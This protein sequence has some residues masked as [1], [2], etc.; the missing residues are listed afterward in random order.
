MRAM[1]LT[2]YSLLLLSTA[3]AQSPD[4][5]SY[6]YMYKKEPGSDSTTPKRNYY[7][8]QST[9]VDS[10]DTA[11]V[12]GF[13]IAPL[14]RKQ[15]ESPLGNL[16][17]DCM[18]LYAER[19]YNTNVDAAFVNFS[20]MRY[21]I[22]KGDITIGTMS[23]VMPYDNKIVLLTIPGSVFKQ[24]LEYQAGLGGWPCSGINMTIK[25]KQVTDILINNQPLDE[26]KNYTIAVADYIAKG[27][28]QCTMLKGLPYLDKNYLFRTALIDYIISFT[29][30]GKPVTA[31]IENR[32]VY[33][34]E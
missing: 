9:Y 28:N 2:F 29:K 15:P 21:Y 12:I 18:K 20:G 22:P 17:A 24:F 7:L 6:E 25:N 32:I 26:T 5:S 3:H 1:L 33:I 31:T 11:K 8:H 34:N 27:G 4:Y 13:A 19:I 10:V 30:S 14:Y 23:K 16:M